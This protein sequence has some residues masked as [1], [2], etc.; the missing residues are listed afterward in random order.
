MNNSVKQQRKIGE[1]QMIIKKYHEAKMNHRAFHET[2][3]RIKRI[4]YWPN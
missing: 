4:N 2:K 1:M 3:K